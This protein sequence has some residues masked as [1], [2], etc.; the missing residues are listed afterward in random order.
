MQNKKL[1]I[2]FCVVLSFH[3]ICCIAANIGCA[4]IMKTK[5]F[6]FCFALCSAFTIFATGMTL[7]L[8]DADEKR[9]N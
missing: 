4:S 2:M 8:I 6:V 5:N 9:T 1:H 3:Y 7:I